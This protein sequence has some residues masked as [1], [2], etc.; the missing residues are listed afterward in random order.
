MTYE[1]YVTHQMVRDFAKDQINLKRDDVSEYR[2]QLG[3]LQDRLKAHIGEHPDYGFVKTRQSGSVSKGTALS[4][5][6]DMDLAVYVEADEAPTGTDAQL[7]SWMQDRLKDALKPLGLKDD[8]FTLQSHC[9]KIEYR[10][11]GLNVDVVPVLYEGEADDVGYLIAKDTGQ[12]VKTSVSQHLEFIRA[13][14][15]EHPDH[16]AQLVRIT[17]WWVRQVKRKNDDFRFKSF[18]VELIWAYLADNGTP[19]D[20]YPVAL[21]AFFGHI[22]QSG[23]GDRISFADYYPASDLPVATGAAIEIFDPVN[24]DNNVPATYTV[25]QRDAIVEAANDAFDALT[26]AQYVEAKGR[27]VDLWQTILGPSF[28]G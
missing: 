22:V 1:T 12:H 4:S 17:K 2:K 23:L 25:Q 11:S 15:N 19:L 18:M 10:G 27:A 24:P 3:R 6:N 21:E 13:R 9:V 14:K 20:D 28:R 26:E 7:L 5:V 16:F 8:Q